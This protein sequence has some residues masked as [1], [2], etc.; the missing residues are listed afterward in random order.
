MRRYGDRLALSGLPNL[1]RC[2][3]I[4]VA[5]FQGVVMDALDVQDAID[6]G[7]EAMNSDGCGNNGKGPGYDAGPADVELFGV[8][9]HIQFGES[10]ST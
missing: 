4:V 1:P 7:N 9:F 8:P 3:R 6:P 2:V 5:Q 10:P